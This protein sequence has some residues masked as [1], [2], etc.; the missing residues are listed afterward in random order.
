[1]QNINFS[2]DDRR[3]TQ[4]IKELGLNVSYINDNDKSKKNLISFSRRIIPG[5]YCIFVNPFFSGDVQT[6]CSL[7]EKA[8]IV[9]NLVTIEHLS[10]EQNQREL[11]NTYFNKNR[12]MIFSRFPNDK[13]INQKIPAFQNYIY[14]RFAGIAK[15]MELN[16][17]LFKNNWDD[18]QNILSANIPDNFIKKKEYMAFPDN[19]PAG[20]DWMT[21][22][23]F[24]C[25]NM[26]HTLDVISGEG[27][28]IK[29]GDIRQ[30]KNEKQTEE[31][32]KDNFLSEKTIIE[33]Y[34]DVNDKRIKRGRTTHKSSANA[35]YSVSECTGLQDL[36]YILKERSFYQQK[37]KL[38]TNMM[39][40]T[41]RNKFSSAVIIPR[42]HKINNSTPANLCILLDVSG[43]LP[44]VFLQN[45]VKTIIK[46]EGIFNKSKSRLVCWSDYL[47]SDT[48][49][50]DLSGIRSG[51]S[52][53]LSGGINYCKRYLTEESAFFLIS[54]FQDDLEDWIKCAK[55]IKAKKTAIG[56][57][58]AVSSVSF[59]KWFSGIGSNSDSHRAEL[60]V[61]QFTDV[62][63]TVLL[64]SS[65]F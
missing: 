24:L 63:D 4:I 43:S 31:Q 54:D 42:R 32:I 36:L 39:Y 48:N 34:D 65:V 23:L 9:Y 13:N 14:T 37:R 25:R 52:T 51:G 5:N 56:Y 10:N 2:A 49:F 8:A 29:T 22:M 6:I 55:D 35:V 19:I 47:I 41:N 27:G 57:T 59:A 58:N 28:Q 17:K 40:H 18:I 20:L 12:S 7:R 33:L 38:Y 61:K 15:S 11:F 3:F 44:V 16:G 46:G 60:S 26:K 21:Y 30:Y 64:R 50:N 1:M 62:F 45:V 53:M